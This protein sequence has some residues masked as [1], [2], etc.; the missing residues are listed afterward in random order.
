MPVQQ[1]DVP[2]LN[3]LV[4]KMESGEL[5]R[6][7][8]KPGKPLGPRSV[9]HVLGRLQQ[10]FDDLVR[11]GKLVRNV[12]TLIERP[13]LPPR[14]D[15]AWTADEARR[16]IQYA[17]R[18]R[19]HPCWLLSLLGL[20]RGEVLRLDWPSIDLDAGTLRIGKAKT[21]SGV[22]TLP[23]AGTGLVEALKAHRKRL[24]AERLA[25]G[26]AY[27]V[28][29]L[30]A[31]DELGRPL[32]PDWY[33]AQFRRLAQAAGVRAIRPH[34]ARHSAATL[35]REAGV[36]PE[37]IAKWLGHARGTISMALYV[38]DPRETALADAG[39]RLGA[40]LNGS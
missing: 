39:A 30:L 36:H 29:D 25:A 2:A 27:T 13:P 10:V 6:R 18:D 40:I 19:L 15:R 33:S 38:D 31:V 14:S 17:A 35:L 4:A 9:Q 21:P 22:R 7:G 24:A 32:H 28:T 3:R 34:D 23:I 37:V 5:R 26:E 11:Q 1:I 12:V 20:R 8:G 16:F